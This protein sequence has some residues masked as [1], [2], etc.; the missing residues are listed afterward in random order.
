M[1]AVLLVIGSVMK[2]KTAAKICRSLLLLMG[3][4]AGW[5]IG[6]FA[7]PY[8]Y[9]AEGIGIVTAACVAAFLLCMLLVW[10]PFG[11]KTRRRAALVIAAVFLL[12]CIIII[13]VRTYENSITEIHESHVAYQEFY[14]GHYAPFQRDT[15]VKTLIGPPSL[16][17]EA[18]LPRL[19]GATALY[20]LYAAFVHA[21]Y[22]YGTYEDYDPYKSFDSGGPIVKCSTTA[23]AFENLLSGRVDAIFVMDISESQWEKAKERE[24]SLSLTPIGSEAFVFFVNKRNTITNLTVVDIR[25]IYSGRITN[26]KEVGGKNNA[27]RAYQRSPNS[28]SQ[29]ALEKIMGNIPIMDPP[30]KDVQDMMMGMYKA[31]ADY[32]NYKNALGYSFLYYITG[33]IA[34][35]EVRLLSVN[36]IEPDAKNIANGRYPFAQNFYVVTVDREPETEEDAARMENTQRLIDW[37]LSPQGQGLVEKTGYVPLF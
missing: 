24:V 35:D 28:G 11:A 3:A 22:P 27:I 14:L 8:I 16:S 18:N 32:K 23:T 6:M 34:E 31:V 2:N 29:T 5:V 4:F 21:V 7:V 20:P 13:G 33:M 9:P 19:D 25:G 30:E 17:I 10:K 1:L 26:W 12:P 36:G 37:I 15:M